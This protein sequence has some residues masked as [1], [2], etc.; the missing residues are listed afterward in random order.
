LFHVEHL[1]KM[2]SQ[3]CLDLIKQESQKLGLS[4]SDVT[5]GHFETYIKELLKWN[6]K[7]NLIGHK[8]EKFIIGNLLI[9][10]LNFFRVIQEKPNGS[11]LDIG[12]GG[13]FPGLPL[14]ISEPRLVMTLVEPNLK[15]VSF[16]HHIIGTFDLKT[17]EVESKRIEEL[18]IYSQF[19]GCFDF[20][21]LKALRLD[22]CLPYVTP[23]LS[24]N[25][26]VVM[27]R[28]PKNEKV[29]EISG[30]LVQREIPYV[31]PCGMGERVL[32]VLI[33]T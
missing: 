4:I 2:E 19:K 12:S 26:K 15:K 24:E 33:P 6:K 29:H 13:G 23:M 9:D 5:I 17:V 30:F 27:S 7:I 28:S 18:N 11:V 10:S 16:L 20:I 21:I 3:S 1:V 25:G 31:L 8:E 14:K 32:T 22:V